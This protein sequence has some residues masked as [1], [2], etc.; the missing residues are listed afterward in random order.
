MEFSA[1][2]IKKVAK[3]AKIK[4]T[5][6]EIETFNQQFASIS[7]V[8]NELQQVNTHGIQPIHNPS[9]AQTLFR[10][11]VITDGN[12]VEE[13]MSNAPKSAYNCFVVPKVVE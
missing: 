2:I 7:T 9:S 12:Y 3:L 6:E 4:L 1:E 5:N 13:V 8:I 10:K 11:D